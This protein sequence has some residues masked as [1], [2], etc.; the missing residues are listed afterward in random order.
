[1]YIQVAIE[2]NLKCRKVLTN[3]SNPVGNKWLVVGQT[4]VDH[5]PAIWQARAHS[6]VTI[7]SWAM[8]HPHEFMDTAHTWIHLSIIQ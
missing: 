7:T 3:K 1:M 4:E 8:S 6:L 5:I 2:K